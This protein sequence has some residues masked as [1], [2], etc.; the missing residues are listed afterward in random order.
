MKRNRTS[1]R[2][3]SLGGLIGIVAANIIGWTGPA[4]A[5]LIS[6]P[7]APLSF[8]Q[9]PTL[10]DTLRNGA[11]ATSDQARQTAQAAGEM[12]RRAR[13]PG[14]QTQ[15]FAVDFQNLQIQF[16]NLRAVFSQVAAFVPQLQSP[17]AANAA[18]ELDAGLNIIAE[19]F[20]PV[21]QQWQAGTLDRRNVV[22]M[23]E[24]LNEAVIEWQKELKKNSRRL[25]VIR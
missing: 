22:M 23:C 24:V 15:N 16:Q 7:G 10:A 8:V 25:G 2:I 20:T 11:Q 14:Y 19:A 21:Q 5:Q 18:A 1:F 12:G 17:R 4:I 3:V 13:S 9:G 6:L